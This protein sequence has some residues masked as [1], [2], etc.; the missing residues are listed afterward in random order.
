[1]K[2]LIALVLVVLSFA[3]SKSERG[4]PVSKDSAATSA[5]SPMQRVS[6]GG[7][8]ATTA[9]VNIP[10]PSPQ[11]MIVRTASLK[12]VVADTSKTVDAVTQAV[13]ALG[14]YV[15]AS[16][17]W[18][19]GEL[20][21]ARLTVR[22]PSARLTSALASIRGLAKRVENETIGSEDVSQEYVDLESQLRNLEATEVELREL[23]KSV[24]LNSKKAVEVLEVHQQLTQIR[25]QI[26]QSKGRMR[27]LAQMA[28]LSTISMEIVPDA[29]KQP[30]VQPGWQPL[31]I[32]K[33]ASRALIGAMQG[34]AT[35]A[36]WL[37]IYVVPVLGSIT[38]ILFGVWKIGRRRSAT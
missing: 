16:N 19:E 17:V 31:V 26:E 27:Y 33:N 10:N 12:I 22:V 1:M 36:I 14:G 4:A 2:K 20:L 9:D 23:L 13:E 38:L 6:S 7:V 32:V 30:V 11:R 5:A 37:V 21:H 18:R 15:S 35:A 24:R 8:G 28:S 29:I 3:C 25:A 34:A